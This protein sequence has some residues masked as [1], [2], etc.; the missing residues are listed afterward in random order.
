MRVGDFPKDPV[1]LQLKSV[2]IIGPADHFSNRRLPDETSWETTR[3]P[4]TETYKLEICSPNRLPSF[5]KTVSTRTA[6]VS[7]G[8]DLEGSIETENGFLLKSLS[9]PVSL[10][11]L[12][13]LFSVRR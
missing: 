5:D 10:G 9:R 11:R 7:S 6:T 8:F 13:S 12:W 3:T 2:I 1:N 4:R